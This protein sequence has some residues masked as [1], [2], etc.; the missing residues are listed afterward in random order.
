MFE[1]LEKRVLTRDDFSNSG[2]ME[3]MVENSAVRIPIS[4]SEARFL[5]LDYEKLA[6]V[7]VAEKDVRNMLN[8]LQP[9]ILLSSS[10]IGG[11]GAFTVLGLLQTYNIHGF[12][13]DSMVY[14]VGAACTFAFGGYLVSTI[15]KTYQKF[16]NVSSKPSRNQETIRTPGRT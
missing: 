16:R 15:A 14:A 7:R 4:R 12:N 5:D 9:N 3:V 13:T 2:E 6:C 8:N 11:G 10:L 1:T